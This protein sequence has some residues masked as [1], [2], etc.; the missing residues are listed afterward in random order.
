[1]ELNIS[2]GSVLGIAVFE[3]PGVLTAR[4]NNLSFHQKPILQAPLLQSLA[5]GSEKTC[6]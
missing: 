5:F 6:K 1:M 4:E 3:L 2:Q